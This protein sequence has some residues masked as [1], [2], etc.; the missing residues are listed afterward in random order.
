MTL[1]RLGRITTTVPCIW[2]PRSLDSI[3]PCT[4]SISASGMWEIV[5]AMEKKERGKKG[6]CRHLAEV[7]FGGARRLPCTVYGIA[8]IVGMEAGG[9]GGS[10]TG[11]EKTDRLCRMGMISDHECDAGT[12]NKRQKRK[13]CFL[14]ASEGEDPILSYLFSQVPWEFRK[15]LLAVR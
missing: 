10:G 9:G 8:A 11:G 3:P 15:G 12:G 6:S 14:G 7:G 4:R 13:R 5:P 2:S 1:R